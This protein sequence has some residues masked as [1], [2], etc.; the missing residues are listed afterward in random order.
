MKINV[1]EY[2]FQTAAKYADKTAVIDAVSEISYADL[3][4]A[5]VRTGNALVPFF[6]TRQ[7]S[8][9]IVFIDKSIPC[10]KAMLGTL[11]AGHY[12]VVM[13]TMTP[14]GRFHE[15]VSILNNRLLITTRE[16]QERVAQLGYE[17][18]VCL[19]EDLEAGSAEHT[20]TG[21]V[22]HKG[23]CAGAHTKAGSAE[24]TEAG[25]VKHK[26]AGGG[27]QTK[28]GGRVQ[29]GAG[30][31]AQEEAPWKQ[32]I[33]TDLVYVLFTSG[34]TGR[35]KGVAV[36][37]RGLIDYVEAYVP[38][39]GIE[40]DDVLGN[41]S[42]FF[43]DVS[44]RDIY[45]AQK[46]GATLCIIPSQYF[47]TLKKLLSFL[48]EKRVTSIAWASTAYRIVAQ[49]HGLDKIRPSALKKFVFCA[50]AMPTA[51]YNYWK[52]EYPEGVFYQQY[53][54]TEI[55]GACCI[56]RVD[57][58]FSDD[59]TIP[60]GR[61]FRNMQLFLIDDTGEAI[62]PSEPNRIGEIY[63][64]GTG[65]A[66]G[67]FNDPDKTDELFVQNPLHDNYPDIVYKSG[68][69][70]YW[71]EEGELVYVSRIDFQI[72][73]GGHRIELGE[74]E[75]GLMAIE[76]I[77]GCCCV[78]NRKDDEIVCFFVGPGKEKKEIMI[79]ARRRLLNYMVPTVYYKVDE[80]PVL[81]NGKVNRKEL[82]DMV[83][84]EDT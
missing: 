20:E 70:A 6:Q 24:H 46:T 38:A 43:F 66:P 12:Y 2:L 44:L 61:P 65:V 51:V 3:A 27:A 16:E 75:N 18:Q 26:G 8:S 73:H 62:L 39:V 55:T 36:T 21:I 25:S 30:G 84:S 83:N 9:V 19:V 49:I 41:Q 35:P 31:K 34:S 10:L 79:E 58:E 13:D 22:E 42:P 32:R 28:A 5:A 4:G 76:G 54:L 63:V 78:Q 80:L 64:R 53:G 17:G 81:P 68:D 23:V 40:P 37:H 45:M 56:Y 50:E 57:R 48:E 52:R 1:L 59:E 67:Y 69:L 11:Y 60:I 47:V 77:M 7:Q 15:I 29:S 72:K 33:D 71:N 74:I 82:D 14:A